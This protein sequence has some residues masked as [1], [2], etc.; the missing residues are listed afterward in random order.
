[1]NTRSRL[2]ALML[3]LLLLLSPITSLAE[4]SP[5]A[6]PPQAV[7]AETAE[8]GEEP[9]MEEEEPTPNPDDEGN[10]GNEGTEAAPEMTAVPF[11]TMPPLEKDDMPMPNPDAKAEAVVTAM[12]GVSLYVQPSLESDALQTLAAGSVVTLLKLNFAW[13]RVQSAG[14][15]GYVP[16]HALSFGYGSPQPGLAKV[17]APGGKLT[18]RADMTTKSKALGTIPSG[19]AVILLA[20]GETFSLV[21]F[22]GKEGYALTVHLKEMPAS[23]ELGTLTQVHSLTEDRV[24]NV[25]VRSAGD[26]KG[27]EYTKIRAG[28]H[29][30]VLEYADGWAMV[31]AEGYHGYMM[32]DYLKPAQ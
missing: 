26:R 6:T 11:A 18:L 8:P 27:R 13:S 25:R 31:E 2:T 1:M 9:D 5:S 10:E 22:E 29:V 20:R 14:A 15:E 23:T 19:R 30:V 12:D 16:T 17:T 7:M 24:A 28:L 4:T 21:R 32:E 3:G